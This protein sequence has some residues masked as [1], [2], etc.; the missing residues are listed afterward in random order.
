MGR[1]AL[2][3]PLVD[4]VLLDRAGVD[5]ETRNKLGRT[6]L[7]AACDLSAIGY[8]SGPDSDI[9]REKV[10]HLLLQHGADITARDLVGRTASDTVAPFAKW[11]AALLRKH[12]ASLYLDNAT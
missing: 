1:L 3:T 11:C 9:K 8:S 5:L 2:F 7:S 10:L 4:R 12:Y 6:A